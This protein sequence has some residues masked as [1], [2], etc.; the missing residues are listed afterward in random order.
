ME[1]IKIKDLKPVEIDFDICAALGN[2]D[3]VHL[4]HQK[5][6]EKCKSQGMKSAILTFYPHPNTFIRDLPNYELLTPYDLKVNI[7]ESVGIDYLIIVEFNEEIARTDY[8]KFIDFMHAMRI[9]KV[10]AGYDFTFGY[11]AQG[12]VEKLIE[13]FDTLIVKKYVL[14]DVRVSTTHVKD[15]LRQGELD[16]ARLYLGRNH[17]IYGRVIHGNS[18]GTD[19]GYPTANIEYKNALLPKNGVYF[20]SVTIENKK[21]YGMANI[22]YNPTCNYSDERK[23]EVHI[24]NLD[25]NLYDRDMNI[26]FIERIRAEKKFKSVE[27]LIDQ[28][29]RDK[30]YCLG[31]INS[32]L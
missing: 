11:K 3:G 5:L 10:V 20:V 18:V 30:E 28:L 13:E 27:L 31:K 22:G 17:M 23:L 14:N 21:Y 7:C 19:I 8:R 15:L 25:N 1:I 26:E 2:F 24:F 32:N 6:I 16:K 29:N 4:G 12:T 9:K